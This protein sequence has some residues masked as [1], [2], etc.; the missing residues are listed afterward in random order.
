MGNVAA[1][2][3]NREWYSNRLSV[4]AGGAGL[5][6]ESALLPALVEGLERYS[7]G[8]CPDMHFIVSSADELGRDAIDLDSI[9]RCSQRELVHPKCPLILPDKGR[10]IRWVRG[11]S[12][13][14]GR[15]AYVPAVMVYSHLVN[16]QPS[17][18][19]WLPIS[20]GCAAHITYEEAL[21]GG[22]Y[23]VAE[24]DAISITWL[25]K[26]KLP[27]IDV[28]VV[29][30]GL[31][32]AWEVHESGSRDV[33]TYFF[34]ATLDL[35][36]PTVY[37]VQ[38]A[39]FSKHATTLI[40][41]SSKSS[42][43]H[44]IAKVILDLAALTQGFRPSCPLPGSWDDYR[45]V[46]HG[47]TYMA[48]YDR[49]HAFDFLLASSEQRKLSDILKAGPHDPSLKRVLQGLKARALS[50]Y[51]ID[52]S[53]DEAVRSGIRVVRVVIP[54]LQPLS[55]RYR[56]RFLGHPRLYDAPSRMGFQS[57]PE[58]E[59]NEFPQPFA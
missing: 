47:A 44:A 4:D 52:I 12:L 57:L 16:I 17:E 42:M 22:I 43:A 1:V 11:L 59:I 19:F 45:Q 50:C 7:T 51:A 13:T 33:E 36:I 24:R 48:Q 18:R 54:G 21:L 25:Q 56:A 34:D 58:E 10:P 46:M 35:G 40:G 28:D 32:A 53:P 2:W 5:S 30:P 6:A 38:V 27:R 20:T 37:A 55:F 49:R 39:P 23:E 26:L 29:P 41:C 15:P 31:A 3:P 14:D 8:T 9:P